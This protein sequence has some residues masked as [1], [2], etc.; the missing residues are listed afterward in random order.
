MP[1][2]TLSAELKATNIDFCIPDPQAVDEWGADDV[3]EGTVDSSA[4]GSFT[5]ASVP[6]QE[7]DQA[8]GS[9]VITASNEPF[10]L[11]LYWEEGT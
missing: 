3:S 8:V 9:S 1:S 6:Q 11:K 2:C 4:N 5:A 10:A 7:N